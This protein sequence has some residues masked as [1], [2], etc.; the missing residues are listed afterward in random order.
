M[1][2][3]LFILCMA[4]TSIMEVH[5][6]TYRDSANNL[7]IVK[8]VPNMCYVE[9][10][11]H[12]IYIPQTNFDFNWDP[13]F[14]EPTNTILS[15]R[16]GCVVELFENTY[17]NNLD[18]PLFVVYQEG[19]SMGYLILPISI[20]E[21]YHQKGALIDQVDMFGYYSDMLLVCNE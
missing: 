16:Y 15:E 6:Q 12:L 8:A 11:I 9:D 19:T 14:I 4:I 10:I 17:D 13:E 1:I 21:E 20:I 18:D 7:D 3:N 5:A 2:K